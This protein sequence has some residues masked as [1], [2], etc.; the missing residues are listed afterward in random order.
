LTPNFFFNLPPCKDTEFLPALAKAHQLFFV[1]ARL[2]G[3]GEPPD[4]Q[5]AKWLEK[6]YGLDHPCV[7]L[8]KDKAA[9][10]DA[11]DI[12]AFIDDRAE[13]CNTLY[14][15]VPLCETVLLAR[16]HNTTCHPTVK[17]VKTFNEFAQLYL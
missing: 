4:V 13:T 8:A 9:I 10:I 3:A 1:S 2:P 11:L 7:I 14:E 15:E 17:R 16:P 6:H 12:Q 5:S